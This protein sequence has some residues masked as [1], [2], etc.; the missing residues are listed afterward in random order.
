[1]IRAFAIGL[2][3]L[4][5][6]SCTRPAEET[7]AAGTAGVDI[8]L[9]RDTDVIDAV[10]PRNATLESLLRGHQ[11]SAGLTSSVVEAVGSVFNP[12]ELRA[13]RPYQLVR[14]LDGLFREFRY[15]IDADR[16]LRVVTRA[17]ATGEPRFDVEVVA[18]PKELTPAAMS[19]EITR[20]RPSLI[21]AFDAL[22]EN[23]QLALQLAE[24]L[25][26]EIDF[27]SDLQPGDRL[28]VL[29]ERALRDSEFAGYGQVE[30]VVLVNEGRRITG[31]R[32]AGPD[33]KSDWYDEEGR[34][35]KRQFLRSPLPFEPRITSGFSYRRLHPVHGGYRAHPGIDY[36]APYGSRVVAVASGL[37][38]SA[39]WSG[40][41][42]RTVRIRHAGGYE[43]LYLH[44]SAF[45]SGIRAGARV[46]QGDL[47]GRVGAS[48]TATGAHLDYRIKKN[49]VYVNPLVELS[50]MPKGNPI[51]AESLDAFASQRDRVLGELDKRISGPPRQ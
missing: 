13:N 14:S 10:V 27:N 49:G 17:G 1:M 31:V 23:V 35:L 15:E 40:E 47:I 30:A 8:A 34:S 44:L 4:L 36:G 48:G 7:R 6:V 33:G 5:A 26:G 25:G 21:A 28:N 11:V 18:I 39:D 51:P 32:F 12:R 37:V 16:L 50:R 3:V 19:A 38:L 9:A 22:G 2:P 43:T 41:A 45:A 29:F 42:G 46:S 20:E 24:I